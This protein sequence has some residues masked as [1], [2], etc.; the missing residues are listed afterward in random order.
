MTIQRRQLL[1]LAGVAG[2]GLLTAGIGSATE[3]RR[4]GVTS[5]DALRGDRR[6]LIHLMLKG[7]N[8][9]L[10]TV[11]PIADPLY[12][13]LRPTLAVSRADVLPLGDGL[14]FNPALRP[15]LS[16]WEAGQCQV[17]LGIAAPVGGSHVSATAAWHAS[18]LDG[19]AGWIAKLPSSHGPSLR[20]DYGLVF[21]DDHAL[22]SGDRL[23]GITMDAGNDTGFTTTTEDSPAARHRQEMAGLIRQATA[24][25]PSFGF[26]GSVLGRR[27]HQTAAL[28]AAGLTPS[29]VVI[30]HDGYDTHADQRGSHDALLADLAGSLDTFAQ[31]MRSI[32]RWDD[33]VIATGS[34]FGRQAAENAVGGTDHGSHS[35]HF[36]MGGAVRGGFIGRQ[37]ELSAWEQEPSSAGSSL[38]S[39]RGAVAQA[40][41]GQLL[42]GA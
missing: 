21:G 27:L 1:A 42:V 38:R 35:C 7:G 18:D 2:I 11:I 12:A 26:T 33:I 16:R 41:T 20:P 31:V 28:L 24:Q 30:S 25:S 5:L 4:L 19:R 29:A 10:N 3:S 6:C 13:R 22:V 8:D 15:L 14:A 34:E 40:M 37:P 9:G 17:H 32:G 36:V 23:V 39:L